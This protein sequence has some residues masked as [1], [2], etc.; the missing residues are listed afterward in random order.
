[1]VADPTFDTRRRYTVDEYELMGRVGILAEDERTELLDGEILAMSPVSPRHASVVSRITRQL[2][3]S[4]GDDVL[5]RVQDPIRLVPR[6]EPQPDIVI[7]RPRRDAYVSA[8]PAAEDIVLL[9]EVANSSLAVGRGN[10]R[11]V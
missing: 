11:A 9:I 1:M 3:R 8:H 2:Y 5:I 7:C 6:S 10:K 4:T